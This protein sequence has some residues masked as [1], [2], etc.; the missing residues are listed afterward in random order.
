M[1][2]HQLTRRFLITAVFIAGAILTIVSYS[3]AQKVSQSELQFREA[4]HKQ[5]VVGDLPAAIKLYQ[6]IAASK[7]ADRAVKARAL[8]QLAACYEKLGQ[9]SE[10][11]Y[12]Q[13]VR[14]FADQPAASQARAKLAALRPPAPSSTQTLRKIELGPGVQNIV[15]TDGQRAVYW[16]AAETTLFFGDVAGKSKNIV[17]TATA[18]RKPIAVASRDLSMVALYFPESGDKPQ[19][20]AVVKTDGTGYYEINATI[21]GTNAPIVPH[22]CLSWSRDNRYIL[23]CRQR[24]DGVHLTQVSVADGQAIDLLPGLKT[25]ILGTVFSPDDRFIAFQDAKGSVYILPAKGSEP[26]LVAES[27]TL[28]DWTEDGKYFVFA[29]EQGKTYSLFAVSIKDGRPAGDRVFIRRL[30]KM[31]GPVRYGSSL[32]YAVAPDEGTDKVSVVSIEGDRLGQ[33]KTLDLVGVGG[34]GPTFSPDATRIAYVSHPAINDRTS[35]VRVHDIASGEDRELFRSNE[36]LSICLWASQRPILYCMSQVIAAKVELL[37]ISLETGRA[38]KIMTFDGPK[39]LSGLS[40]DD[41]ILYMRGLSAS[42]GPTVYQWEIGSGKAEAPVARFGLLSLDGRWVLTFSRDSQGRRGFQI[43]PASGGNADWRHL[44][45]VRRQAPPAGQISPIA[46]TPDGNWFLFHDTDPDGKDGL[47]RVS[48]SGGEAHRLGDYPTSL[49][50]FMG[51]S[52]DGRHIL[53]DALSATGKPSEYWVL[54]NFIP[55]TASAAKR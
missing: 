5:Q 43:G 37:S 54:Q 17:L 53:V 4:L 14:D 28:V 51:T 19:S 1:R 39:E 20:Y 33:W 24:A 49:T 31:S 3:T 38:E 47:Y 6:N 21:D 50:S 29:A 34:F 36:L 45:Y 25:V 35:A 40:P 13:I 22:L 55:P 10:R 11:V 44:V 52:A 32:V 27:A 12:Q 8:L 48:T 2:T 16:D 9:Q 18:F 42:G 30:E 26:Q 15:A 46:F 23:Q 41:R 7:T